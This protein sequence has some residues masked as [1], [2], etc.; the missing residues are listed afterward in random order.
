MT[1][2]LRHD[3]TVRRPNFPFDRDIPRHWL[4]DSAAFTHDF[5]GLNLLFPDGER[6]FVK[7][8]LDAMRELPDAEPEL[9]RA[10]RGF[11]GQ[12][13]SHAREHERYFEILEAQGYRVEEF[14]R[15][16]RRFAEWTNR[17]PVSLRLSMTAA[18]EHYTAVMGALVLELDLLDDAHP[19]MR[20]L[21]TWHALEEIEHKA[22][23]FD[24]LQRRNGSYALRMVGWVI[25]TCSLFG[26]AAAGTRML[27]RQDGVSGSEARAQRRAFLR[28]RGRGLLR[29]P[30]ARGLA[31]LRPRFHPHQIDD[32]PMARERFARSRLAERLGET[33]V[34]A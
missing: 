29:G 25:A 22:V 18:A 27:L 2:S 21:I 4:A 32:L 10:V 6:F 30:L 26:W 34:E 16:F 24:V 12:E 31:Y 3:I 14:L 8:V 20:D 9:E 17:L 23:A 5:N 7:A 13:G 1:E 11:A 19:V 33:A 28:E 15:R